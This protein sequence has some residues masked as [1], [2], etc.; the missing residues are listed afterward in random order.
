[1]G[2]RR[3]LQ[4][5]RFP[6]RPGR[7]Q[8]RSVAAPIAGKLTELLRRPA[9]PTGPQLGAL[10]ATAT[11][12]HHDVSRRSSYLLS[13]PLAESTIDEIP[14]VKMR[15]TTTLAAI[16]DDVPEWFDVG[17]FLIASLLHRIVMSSLLFR[18]VSFPGVFAGFRSTAP[19]AQTRTMPSVG[20]V[21]T[22]MS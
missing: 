5:F 18:I 9:G 13:A 4:P 12:N 15:S 16:V 10:P 1:M 11:R 2:P 21:L 17:G 7:R 6:A 3:K 20:V 8:Q 19:A 22:A 14:A